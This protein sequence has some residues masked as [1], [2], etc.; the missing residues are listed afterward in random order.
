MFFIPS[1]H[2]LPH[3]APVSAT[4]THMLRICVNPRHPLFSGRADNACTNLLGFFVHYVRTRGSMRLQ[5]VIKPPTFCFACCRTHSPRTARATNSC[6]RGMNQCTQCVGWRRRDWG[7]SSQRE[8][9]A[10]FDDF[11]YFSSLKST[12]K[13]KFLYDTSLL[14]FFSRAN[15]V[16]PYHAKSKSP[17]QPK[18]KIKTPYAFSF[19]YTGAKEKAIKKKTPKEDFALCGVR[20]PLSVDD[21]AF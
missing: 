13:E 17:Q 5:R 9:N 12:I 16:R 3:N 4:P 1:A 6:T 20:P 14:E 7:K 18:E 8:G 11:W 21:T 19:A 15:I 2:R 10:L